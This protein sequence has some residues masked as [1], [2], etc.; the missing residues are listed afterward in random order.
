MYYRL[1]FT[2]VEN[3]IDYCERHGWRIIAL[4]VTP[5]A[6]YGLAIKE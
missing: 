6:V 4:E 5:V 3:A 2:T 1:L